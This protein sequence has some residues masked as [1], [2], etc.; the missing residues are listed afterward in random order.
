[1]RLAP[2]FVGGHDDAAHQR[3][4]SVDAQHRADG[5]GVR[6]RVGDAAERVAALRER[7]APRRACLRRRS[8]CRSRVAKSGG[9]ISSRRS[10][11]SSMPSAR[12]PRSTQI[13]DGGWSSVDLPLVKYVSPASRSTSRTAAWNAAA[14]RQVVAAETAAQRVA[15]AGV[16]AFER[17]ALRADV[18]ERVAKVEDDGADHQRRTV[19][20]AAPRAQRAAP[21]CAP[22]RRFARR[23]WRVA[24]AVAGGPAGAAAPRM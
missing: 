8:G 1:M 17:A 12:Q 9:V 14:P 3:L 11:S 16:R 20:S 24:A 13:H 23:R 10:R 22:R 15:H 18:P 4:E 6:Q 2:S 19:R 7:R 5:G 21:A